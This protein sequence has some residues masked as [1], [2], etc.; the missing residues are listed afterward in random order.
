MKKIKNPL[1]FIFITVLIDCIGIRIIYPV[2][3]SIISEVSGVSVNEAVTYSGWLMASYAVMQFLFSP[4]L[5]ALSDRFGRRPV[6]LLSLMGFGIDY[7]FL[8]LA[9]TLPLLFLGRIISGICGASI[10]TSFAYVADI[11]SPEKRAQNFGIIGAAIGLGFIIGPFMGGMLSEFGTR[12]PFFASAVLSL[13]NWLYGFFILPESL[14]IENRRKFNLKRANP[15]GAFLQLKKNKAIRMLLVALFFL[16]VAGQVMPA[17]WPFYTKY[18]YKWSDL[19]IG[20]SLAF[21]GVMVAIV[22]SGLI[23]WTQKFFGPIRSVYIG[24]LFYVLGL[25]LF[26]CANQP[27]MLYVFILVYCLGGIAL[28][29]LQAIISG[30]MH[31]NE[32]GELQGMITSLISLSNILAPLIMTHLFYFFTKENGSVNFPGAPFAVAAILVSIGIAFCIRELKKENSSLV[33][34][35]L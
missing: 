31:A 27:W 18:L 3:A 28:P 17:V 23:R 35:N 6:L 34:N 5:G 29:S 25:S 22:K 11:S 10:T 33:N 20:Y 2:A 9:K 26:A 19:E 30:R 24:L 15:F 32:Q 13:L 7:L 12:V 8:A 16:F 4:I 14:K 21:V 1:V